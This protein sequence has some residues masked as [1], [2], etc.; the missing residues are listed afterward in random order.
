MPHMPQ[1]H[2]DG[3]PPLHPSPT[4][5]WWSVPHWSKSS[6]SLRSMRIR[7]SSPQASDQEFW[8]VQYLTREPSTCSWP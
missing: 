5:G 6:V 2:T 7:P 3:G 4:S 8:I 1:T